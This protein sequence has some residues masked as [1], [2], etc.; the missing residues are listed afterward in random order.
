MT[1]FGQSTSDID[2]LEKELDLIGN[3][4]GTGCKLNVEQDDDDFGTIP[5]VNILDQ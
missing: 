3:G 2:D 1:T 4:N 5:M